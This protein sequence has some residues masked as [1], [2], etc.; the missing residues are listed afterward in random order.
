MN[1]HDPSG[2]VAVWSAILGGISWAVSGAM[3]A[4]HAAGSAIQNGVT[5]LGE[6]GGIHLLGEG[7]LRSVYEGWT[8]FVLDFAQGVQNFFG[9]AVRGMLEIG[10][11][12]DALVRTFYTTILENPWL[13]M[14]P[15]V[16][17]ALR[18]LNSNIGKV[19]RIIRRNIDQSARR[20]GEMWEQEILHR[21]HP[22]MRWEGVDPTALWDKT[23]AKK[24][25]INGVVN[26]KKYLTNV[27]FGLVPPVVTNLYLDITGLRHQPVNTPAMIA[28]WLLLADAFPELPWD[29][30]AEMSCKEGGICKND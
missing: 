6:T 28:V 4:L 1:L 7:T 26:V 9:D 15:G 24:V 19:A 5:L 30:L 10:K 25:L 18:L 16:A 17:G 22:N 29:G 3:G 11:T 23:A 12:T 27:G 2:R 13:L 8:K 21:R 14:F 20:I